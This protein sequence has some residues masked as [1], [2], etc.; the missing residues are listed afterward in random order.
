MHCKAQLII[1]ALHVFQ[2]IHAAIS[3]NL[4]SF[5]QFSSH[6]IFLVVFLT[7]QTI[8]YFMYM[9]S[10][11]NEN[12]TAAMSE[13]HLKSVFGNYSLFTRACVGSNR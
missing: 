11:I 5:M 8:S 1:P 3:C 6:A 9:L 2:T 4:N 12:L 10:W 13:V 7:P